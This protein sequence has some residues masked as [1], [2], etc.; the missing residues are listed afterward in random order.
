MNSIRM[1][2]GTKADR[3]RCDGANQLRLGWTDPGGLLT[4]TLTRAVSDI[5]ISMTTSIVRST[6]WNLAESSMPR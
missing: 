4:N 6:R 5:T 2:P 3:G 1:S